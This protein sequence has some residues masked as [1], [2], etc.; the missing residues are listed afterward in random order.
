MSP[1]PFIY[2]TEG[3][4]CPHVRPH[5]LEIAD[6]LAPDS[7]CKHTFIH[8]FFSHTATFIV[9]FVTDPTEALKRV[10][11]RYN[12]YEFSRGC[13]AERAVVVLQQ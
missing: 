3:F 13:H 7:K 6:G 1:V 8:F 11:A 10:E 12:R 9:T 5:C 2:V 4:G